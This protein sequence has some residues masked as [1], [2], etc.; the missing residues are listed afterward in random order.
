MKSFRG[1]EVIDWRI[2]DSV[3][4]SDFENKINELMDKYN[5]EDFQFST[6][7]NYKNYA[8]PP[9]V[10]YSAAILISKKDN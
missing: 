2:I 5:F 1:K 7:I 8:G 6:T 10:H 4:R 3:S 9:F